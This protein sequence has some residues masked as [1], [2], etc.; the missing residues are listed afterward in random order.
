MTKEPD[1]LITWLQAAAAWER[2]TGLFD[3]DDGGLTTALLKEVICAGSVVRTPA[4]G[5]RYRLRRVIED[6]L[7]WQQ[8]LE[9]SDVDQA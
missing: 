8:A 3:V 4:P 7:A 9:V 1:P 6:L 5:P 2:A